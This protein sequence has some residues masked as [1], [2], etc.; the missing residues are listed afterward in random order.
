M[1]KSIKTEWMEM[2]IVIAPD[3]F[4]ESMTAY[5][6][7][8]AMERAVQKVVPQA[9]VEKVPIADGGEGTVQALVDALDGEIVSA[10][11]TG[12]LGEKIESYYGIIHEKIA[13]IE[14]ASVCGLDL[15]S[16]AERNPLMMTSYGV[17]EM[18]VHALDR[19]IREFVIGLGGSGTNDGGIG[20]A[21]ALGVEMM[22]TA[23]EQ[24]CF[25]GN[26]L[27]D[28]A[29]ISVANLDARLS[30]CHFVVASDVTNPLLGEGGA[31]YV[32]GPQKGATP[33]MV[34]KLDKAMGQYA[35]VLKRDLGINV[36]S[37]RG[38]G[39]AGGLG[40][41]CFVFLQAQLESGIDYIMSLT[42][43][44]NKIRTADLVLTGEG[45]IDNQTSFGKAITGIAR[46]AKEDTVPVIALTGADVTT[47]NT[48]YESGVTAVF[49]L[50]NAPMSLAEAM[51]NGLQ[52]TERVTENALR[53]FIQRY[54]KA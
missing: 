11:V 20:M 49:T 51:E 13:V 46:V 7:A 52:L 23:K 37:E 17:G 26:G 42:N 5:E 47:T 28:I 48:L 2:N 35:A 10:T 18:I 1:I 27:V 44:V 14:V 22:D 6:V 36:A 53:L 38:A 41:A 8:S 9:I 39:A 43:L 16:P 50:P 34:E 33:D 30:D 25:G 40:A 12:P 54:E 19:G 24:V 31:T 29:H 4:K 45:K 32:Y 3:S 15:I 21:Q